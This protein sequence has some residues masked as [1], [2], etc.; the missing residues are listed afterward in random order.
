MQVFIFSS[1]KDGD[2]VAFT[3]DPDG[4][5]LPVELAPWHALSGS[6]MQIRP[7]N[8]PTG[9]S[10]NMDA[11]TDGIARDGFYLTRAEVQS[12]RR[13]GVPKR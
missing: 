6:A 4:R 13:V 9:V 10:G 5:N 12:T 1:E 3:E 2:I 11:V 8:R 7:G